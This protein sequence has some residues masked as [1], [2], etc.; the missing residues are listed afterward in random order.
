MSD[1]T[2]D[3]LFQLK[4]IICDRMCKFDCNFEEHTCKL[5][6]LQ[7]SAKISDSKKV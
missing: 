7:L 5:Y 3:V 6:L 4:T 2:A 1:A